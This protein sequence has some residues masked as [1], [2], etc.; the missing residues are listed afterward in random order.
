MDSVRVRACSVEIKPGTLRAACF[1]VRIQTRI[2]FDLQDGDFQYSL[3][4]G[5]LLF[6][7]IYQTKSIISDYAQDV[8]YISHAFKLYGQIEKQL[9]ICIFTEAALNICKLGLMS[10]TINL[11][12]QSHSDCVNLKSSDQRHFFFRDNTST[13]V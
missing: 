1:D 9:T 6:I 3:Q 8:K 2:R 11:S 4:V 5:Y 12:I 10:G 7:V 13:M